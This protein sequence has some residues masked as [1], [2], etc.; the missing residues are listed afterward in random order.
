MAK[1]NN[2]MG[3]QADFQK[4][5]LKFKNNLASQLILARVSQKITN[6]PAMYSFQWCEENKTGKLKWNLFTKFLEKASVKG[7]LMQI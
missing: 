6:S 7:T 4:R 1:S 5:K 3:G 2:T